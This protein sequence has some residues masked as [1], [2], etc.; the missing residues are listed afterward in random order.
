MNDYYFVQ[1]EKDQIVGFNLT[2]KEK[3][4][5]FYSI[6]SGGGHRKAATGWCWGGVRH[7]VKT[8]KELET[9]L[10]M[11]SSFLTTKNKDWKRI[12]IEQYQYLNSLYESLKLLNDDGRLTQQILTTS[13]LIV[14]LERDHGLHYTTKKEYNS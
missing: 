10:I 6:D 4:E 9:Y 1:N 14:K 11:R 2:A 13:K 3:D 7:K 8:A 5:I 12:A